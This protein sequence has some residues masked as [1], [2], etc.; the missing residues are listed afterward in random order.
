MQL[1]QELNAIIKE[2]HLLTHPFYVAW[3]KGELSIEVLQKYAAQYYHQVKTFPRFLAAAY[4]VSDDA[5]T[6]DVLLENLNDENGHPELWRDFAYGLGVDKETLLNEIP[7]PE[8]Q[9]LVDTYFDLAKNSQDGLCALYAYESQVPD[10]AASKIQGLKDFYDIKDEKTLE[11]FV[12]HQEYDV[13]H[14]NKVASLL[15]NA[16]L[17]KAQEATRKACDAQWRF[18]DG[19]CRISGIVCENHVAA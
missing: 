6:H 1:I 7:L 9:Q 17:E 11:F 16:D 13:D 2:R 3:S 19:M 10:V 8:T 4:S 15:V 18:L 5:H 12:A 14:A